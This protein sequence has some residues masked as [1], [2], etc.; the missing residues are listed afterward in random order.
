LNE[1]AT[2]VLPI[3]RLEQGVYAVNEGVLE[4]DNK[5]IGSFLKWIN[6]DL[7][8]ETQGELEACGLNAKDAYRRCS[9]VARN[10]YISQM[11]KL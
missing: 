7:L 9:E 6:E 2:L 1:F 5:K 4:F 11:K 10:W 3:S 8:K